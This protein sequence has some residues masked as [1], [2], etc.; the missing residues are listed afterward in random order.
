MYE[1]FLFRYLN[2]I[3]LSILIIVL[4]IIT[5]LADSFITV[6]ADSGVSREE[7]DEIDNSGS[8]YFIFWDFKRSIY[9]DE[10]DVR[11]DS[12]KNLEYVGTLINDFAEK[13]GDSV[14]NI[15]VYYITSS[16][17]EKK[18]G[19]FTTI[20]NKS[21]VVNQSDIVNQSH[22]I[23]DFV[24]PED[25]DADEFNNELYEVLLEREDKE[26]N[27]VFVLLTDGEEKLQAK[28][29]DQ[30]N[31]SKSLVYWVD[32]SRYKADPDTT[33]KQYDSMRGIDNFYKEDCVDSAPLNEAEDDVLFSIEADVTKKIRTNVTKN[34]NAITT[35]EITE[36]RVS[37]EY[38]VTEYEI[39]ATESNRVAS[40]TDGKKR[41]KD[42]KIPEKL[43]KWWGNGFVVKLVIIL[44]VIVVVLAIIFISIVRQKRKRKLVNK[45]YRKNNN[46]ESEITDSSNTNN[47]SMNIHIEIMGRNPDIK[48]ICVNGSIFIGRSHTCD[49]FI[50]E[51]T[52]SRQHIALECKNGELFIQ[53]LMTATNSTK[54]NDEIITSRHQLFSGDRLMVGAV[55]IV[56]R[57]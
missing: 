14:R 16:G 48:D 20:K 10:A 27:K 33:S 26:Q 56:V 54:L 18:T 3:C 31:K 57:W 6:Y 41:N 5:G 8:D 44:A 35:E 13:S 22:N 52:V 38:E 55:G 21:G 11:N 4:I 43:K 47:D 32:I 17:S 29:K 50:N 28:T 9:L 39:T 49:V 45:K 34:K 30:V 19:D 2:R 1:S 7:D 53:P 25:R 23:N 42:S 24:N 37:T 46:I 15:E 40:P 12:E 36:S 51:V